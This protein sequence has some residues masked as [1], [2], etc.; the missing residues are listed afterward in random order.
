[1]KLAF[2]I[3]TL[4]RTVFAVLVLLTS[5]G[6]GGGCCSSE[7]VLGDETG[8]T[9]VPDTALTYENFGK[10][11]MTQYCVRCHASNLSGAA[12]Q[13][14]PADHDLDSLPAIRGI[15]EHVDQTAGASDTVTNDTMPPDG[16]K[17]SPQER[18]D[19]ATWIACDLPER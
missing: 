3:V 12:R 16:L 7:G 5:M 6:H 1:M 14:A 4:R 19:L 15:R 2:R 13:G 17:P 11:F 9:C 8:A 18:K 10:E